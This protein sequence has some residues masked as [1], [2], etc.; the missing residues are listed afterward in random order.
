[1]SNHERFLEVSHS[2][3]KETEFPDVFCE[4]I[5]RRESAIRIFETKDA[6]VIMD[7]KGYPLVLSKNHSEESIPEILRLAGKMIIPVKKA[8][9]ASGVRIQLN[10]G[11][12]AGQDIFHPHVHVIPRQQISEGVG[13]NIT[14]SDFGEKSKMA[15]KIRQLSKDLVPHLDRRKM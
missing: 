10:Y 9:S 14:I 7:L 5:N 2:S 15:R 3:I 13:R 4:I 1:M 8:Y 11:E 6:S 12:S